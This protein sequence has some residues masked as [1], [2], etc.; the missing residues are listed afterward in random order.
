M[1]AYRPVALFRHA[2]LR[3]RLPSVPLVA[4]T[5]L[6]QWGTAAPGRQPFDGVGSMVNLKREGMK[7]S[8]LTA[9][10]AL[11]A[12]C[13]QAFG[14]GDT[15]VR[16]FKLANGM[17]VWLSED[18]S[19][20]KVLGAVVVKAG[21]NQ[22]PN[23]GIAHYF[24]HLMFKG[25]DKIGTTDYE[26]EKPWL[27]S[28]AAK[29]DLLAKTT[30]AGVR[31]G[32]QADIN[33]LSHK[34][35]EYVIP[36]EFNNLISYFGGSGLNAATSY[37]FTIYYNTFAPEFVGQWA[38]LCSERMINPV[39]RMF[40]SEL[41]TVYEEKNM[42][43]DNLLAPAMEHLLGAVLEGSPYVHPV[44]GS[45]ESLKNPSLNEMR[46]FFYKYYVAGNMG[47]IMCG[48]ICADT[49]M[50]L[51]ERSF[52]RIRPGCAPPSAP[53][54]LKPFDGTRT[55]GI[56]LP[57]PLVKVTAL[58]YHT[59]T[60]EDSDY[61]ALDMASQILSNGSGSGLLDSLADTKAIMAGYA[62]P[63]AFKDAGFTLVGAVPKIPFGSKKK[64][65]RL[66][67]EM[68]GKV[69]RGE[70]P[71][72]MLDALKLAEELDF[73]LSTETI[74]GRALL[75]LDAFGYGAA[76][77]DDYVGRQSRVAQLTKADV[78]AAA[79]KYFDGNYMRLVKKFGTYQKD[80]LSQPGY[81]P[82]TP[83]NVD[84]RSDYARRLVGE[85]PGK[86]SPRFVNFDS[87]ARRMSLAPLATLYAVRND[88]NDV[89]SIDFVFAKG[90]LDD[91]LASSVADYMG[92]LGTDS[93]SRLGLSAALARLG[94]RLSFGS[95]RNSF[96]ISLMGLDRN[97]E[98][99]MRLFAHFVRR[100][101]A[102]KDKM[103]ELVTG[104]KLSAGTFAEDYS[105]IVRA[106][107]EKIAYGDKSSYLNAVTAGQ[108]KRIGADGMVK[109][110]K[111]LL[112]TECMVLYCG[113][114]AADSVALAVRNSIDVDAINVPC[115]FINRP[116]KAYDRP[117][118]FVYN[119]P[120]ARQ[121]NVGTYTVL[122]PSPTV[123]RRVTEQLWAEY[124]GGSMSSVLFQEMREFRSLAYSS[125][126]W[127]TLPLLA[128][129][130]DAPTAF[131][132]ITGTQADKVLTAVATVDSLFDN[133]PL[134][135]SGFETARRNLLNSINNEYPS[136][137]DVGE[138]IAWR[139]L[140]GYDSDPE[141]QRVPLIEKAV[142]SDVEGFYSD[143]V[144]P[145]VRVYLVVGNIG[146]AEM[147]ALEKYGEVVELRK[148]DI[149]SMFSRKK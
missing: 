139:R 114:M 145:A 108:L 8:L 12:C 24:E 62:V 59:P 34:A 32:L 53:F 134:R 35:A 133:M 149:S 43:A 126:G 20:P 11:V 37:D 99:T 85:H 96:T 98:P 89:F 67:L 56:K 82:V 75:M 91:P 14:T 27:D 100:V 80:R 30:D 31:R 78:M 120:G 29:Y 79:N 127:L 122:P 23:T 2:V 72:T 63:A 16:Q 22:C 125:Y 136:M 102:D 6:C 7:K 58:A 51:L 84:A 54:A 77:W 94:S 10:I 50:P 39:F 76:S 81:K 5:A 46:E 113:S 45:T 41:E 111:D 106:V 13:L 124:F 88:V 4:A 15:S 73:K 44:I 70:F 112:H 36:N 90:T 116:L 141:R 118:V 128:K 104:A 132:T 57:I 142:A 38:E 68:I 92:D 17:T 144:R 33:R 65:E 130:G 9:A 47:L 143:V 131:H 40:Q 18:H 121:A 115:R 137:R 83:R 101:K 86:V 71:D 48:D 147:K 74:D 42:V 60:E 26:A 1:P 97:F 95:D 110:F 148:G 28:I 21:A 140:Y 109:W 69:K 25:T 93:L 105:D 49:L 87:C 119:A 107:V 129:F 19:Q 52:G 3:Q 61:V 123:P 64:A 66:C 146:K 55:V 135:L 138:Y 117:M 103:A